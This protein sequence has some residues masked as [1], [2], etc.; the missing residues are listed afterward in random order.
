M[1][2]TTTTA[3]TRTIHPWMVIVAVVVALLLCVGGLYG[4]YAIGKR[5]SPPEQSGGGTGISE[6]QPVV[7]Q[8]G[9]GEQPPVKVSSCLSIADFVR[10]WSASTPAQGPGPLIQALNEVWDQNGLPGG[11]S[12]IGTGWL[13]GPMA[14]EPMSLVW[15]DLLSNPAPAPYGKWVPL[16]TQGNWGVFAVYDRLVVPTPGRSAR[17]CESLDPED[18]LPGWK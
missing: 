7:Q 11:Q 18:Q 3:T 6:T 14:V 8:P 16:R 9:T 2:T 15:T 1:T 13:T 12:R 5:V 4:A 17:M 10:M